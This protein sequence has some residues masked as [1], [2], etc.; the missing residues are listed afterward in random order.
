MRVTKIKSSDRENWM[1]FLKM[2]KEDKDGY[3]KMWL[4][5][6]F[7][8]EEIAHMVFAVPYS[9]LLSE[10][11]D[12]KLLESIFHHSDMVQIED[13]ESNWKPE[14]ISSVSLESDYSFDL[15]YKGK[16]DPKDVK[17]TLFGLLGFAPI[18]HLSISFKN[19]SPDE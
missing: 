17:S 8:L 16:I 11:R 7:G 10:I 5:N 12:N 9:F 18:G 13:E 3:L 4:S 14:C 1:N 6:G 15:D 19:E 2:S